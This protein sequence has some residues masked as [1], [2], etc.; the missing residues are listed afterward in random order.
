MHLATN[1]PCQSSP[2][3]HRVRDCPYRLRNSARSLFSKA[4]G[5][6]RSADNA[7]SAKCQVAGL[8]RLSDAKIDS[9]FVAVRVRI[10]RPG[11]RQFTVENETLADLEPLP[12][13]LVHSFKATLKA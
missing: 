10:F 2:T 12:G 8:L 13:R 1:I 11:D 5:T 6:P 4:Y 7:P 9:Q 3:D